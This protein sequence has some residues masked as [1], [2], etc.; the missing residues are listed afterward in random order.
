MYEVKILTGNETAAYAAMN[1]KARVVAAYPITPVTPVVETISKL[2]EEGRMHAKF[3]RVESE[4]SA[5]AACI[6]ASAAGSRAFTATSSHGLAYMH[7][8]LH[9]ATN[10]RT[11]IVMAVANRAIGPGWNIWADLGDALSQRDTGWIQ[12][13]CSNNQEIYDTIAMA[14]KLAE[15]RK[16]LLPAMVCYD[17]FVLSHTSM[18]VELTEFDD[19]LSEYEPVWKLDAE[20]PFTHGNILPPEDFAELRHNIQKSHDRALKL[21]KKIEEEFFELYGRRTP[22]ILEEY[23]MEDAE[24][25]IVTMGAIGS[26]AKVAVDSLREKKVKAGLVRLKSFRP[27]PEKELRNLLEDKKVYVF[28]RAIS[29]GSGGPLYNE[30]K[31]ALAFSPVKRIIPKIVGIGG[32]DVT[33]RTFERAI[34]E[35]KVWIKEVVS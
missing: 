25:V 23:K 24:K 3:I 27:F 32:I 29:P 4:H 14:Y 33:K 7:E 35:R 19:F 1:S 9:W 12:F 15:D 17:G 20:N 30:L 21:M 11:P 28:D 8:M 18:P 6:G 5:M 16:V 2:V 34:F 22:L 26:E 10:A 31:S 13:Y